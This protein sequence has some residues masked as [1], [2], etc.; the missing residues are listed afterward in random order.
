MQRRK[1]A[2]VTAE[3][4]ESPVRLTAIGLPSKRCSINGP[5]R[6]AARLTQEVKPPLPWLRSQAQPWA[7]GQGIRIHCPHKTASPG[8]EA[9]PSTS[10]LKAAKGAQRPLLA[11]TG[12]SLGSV[13]PP[14]EQP[15]W[16]GCI[17]RLREATWRAQKHKAVRDKWELILTWEPT[18]S[19][20]H[21]AEDGGKETQDQSPST[22]PTLYSTGRQRWNG[23]GNL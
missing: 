13:C 1:R 23:T 5:P 19:P 22:N 4:T 20:N 9:R 21:Q 17:G 16:V 7:S 6:T 8:G 11:T 12:N 14:P 15:P 10:E 2:K 18:C 3:Q